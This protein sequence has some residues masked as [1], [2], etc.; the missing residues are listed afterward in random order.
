MIPGATLPIELARPPGLLALV[1]PLIVLL[2]SRVL[3]RPVA[4][5]TGTLDLWARVARALPPTARRSRAP[6]PLAVWVLVL[7]LALGAIAL[8]GP[9]LPEPLGRRSLRV[10][11][12]R[13]PSMELPL[14]SGTRRDRA[15]AV[16]REWIE[17]NEPG[18]RVEWIDRS[19]PFGAAEDLWDAVWVT[20][21]APSPAPERAGYFASGGPAVPGPIAVDG[22]TR[23]D[24]DG[25]RIIEVKDGAPARRVEV[26]GELPAPLARVL[27]AWAAARGVDVGAG[28]ERPALVVSGPVPSTPPLREIDVGRDGWTSRGFAADPFEPAGDA[29]LADAGGRPL[30]TTAPGRV[31]CAL[32]AMDDPRGDPA[33][34]AVSWAELFDR[35]LLPPDGVVEL[36]ERGSA[37]AEAVRPPRRGTEEEVTTRP[38]AWDAWLAAASLA[39]VL[40]ALGLARSLR[41]E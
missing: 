12:D 3:V 32:A 30:V 5:A 31:E 11:V 35:V 38:G 7:G 13:S 6:I 21:R 16:A 26:Q 28:A 4:V 1:L 36:S 23:Y 8:A 22:S 40:L 24:W 20:D 33:A 37:G 2:A 17:R 10:I 27:G 34:F 41:M 14:G 9:R 39:C 18:A 15:T 29:W 25:E 19:E